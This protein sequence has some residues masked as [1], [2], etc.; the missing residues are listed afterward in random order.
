MTLKPNRRTVLK[1]FAALGV[2]RAAPALIAR[3]R[4]RQMVRLVVDRTGAMR[5]IDRVVP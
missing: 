2:A 3:A 5:L 4:P 1:G